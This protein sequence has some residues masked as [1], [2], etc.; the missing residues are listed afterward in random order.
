M[1]ESVPQPVEL[2]A[3]IRQVIRMSHFSRV[4]LSWIDFETAEVQRWNG[5]LKCDGHYESDL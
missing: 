5:A 3:E 1:L 2:A 4:E